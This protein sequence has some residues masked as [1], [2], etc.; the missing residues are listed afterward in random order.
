MAR[1]PEWWEQTVPAIFPQTYLRVARERGA[2]PA[3]ILERAGLKADFQEQPGELTMLEIQTLVETVLDTVGDNGLGI[4]I[5][6]NL[7]PTAYGSFGYALLCS[8]SMGD[9]LALTERYWHLVGR[10]TELSVQRDEPACSMEVT[11]TVPTPDALRRLIFETTFTSLYRGFSLLTGADDG[12]LEIWFDFPPP[13]HADV[14][15]RVL[16]RVRYDMPRNQLRFPRHLLEKRLGMHNPA[17]LQFA[18]EQVEREDALQAPD[19]GRIVNRVREKML[20]DVNGY[21][22][23][24]AISR[25][26]NMTAR[27]LRRRLDQ[28]GT[29][30]KR[31]MEEAKRRD[32][33]QLLDD[34]KLDIQRVA[35]LLG[36]Q[37]PANFT[38]AFR[39]WT[40]QTPSQYRA[41]RRSG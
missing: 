15:R 31:L 29:S 26:L 8:E 4:E 17:A 24:E 38:R 7:P 13:E 11:L 23:L 32:A 9:V 12:E 5:G 18:L 30:F 3:V 33:L 41:T 39:Q 10:G 14:V 22:T 20:F 40:G 37:D 1:K 35:Q 25:Q 34:P 36:Y 27:T 19:S 16:R 21:P 2:D 6:W 28:E